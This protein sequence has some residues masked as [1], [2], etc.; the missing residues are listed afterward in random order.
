M[1]LSANGY[2]EVEQYENDRAQ[3]DKETEIYL[4][5]QMALSTIKRA[6]AD[7]SWRCERQRTI[8]ESNK[9]FNETLAK[10]KLTAFDSVNP[11]VKPYVVYRVNRYYQGLG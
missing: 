11:V 4:Q 6:L 9:I 1:D 8:A 2:S 3:R 10:A 7:V 5:T